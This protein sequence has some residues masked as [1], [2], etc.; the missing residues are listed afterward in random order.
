MILYFDSKGKLVQMLLHVGTSEN[1]TPP[2]Q[3]GPLP[4]YLYFDTT[5][6][7]V[8]SD[9]VIHMRYKTPGKSTFS[10]DCPMTYIGTPN[11]ESYEHEEIGELVD[12]RPY[13][14]YSYVFASDSPA[15]KTAGVVNLSFK[16]YTRTGTASNYSYTNP[17]MLSNA[18]VFVEETLGLAPDAS[19]GM[20]P[21]EYNSL[22]AALN[23]VL[24][25]KQVIDSG[26]GEFTFAKIISNLIYK[27][28][29]EI[30]NLFAAKG[31]DATV[32]FLVKILTAITVQAATIKLN[33][34]DITTLFAAKAG[35]D[36]QDF[37]VKDLKYHDSNNVE[38]SLISKMTTIEALLDSL[39][40][41]DL[42]TWIAAMNQLKDN[43]EEFM[44][45]SSSDNII[46]T[47]TELRTELATK[48]SKTYVDGQDSGLSGEIDT[49]IAAFL[50][51][52]D[53]ENKVKAIIDEMF[54]DISEVEY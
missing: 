20:T 15:V 11:F 40:N 19:I 13:K 46:N 25:L 8:G 30:S 3:C 1:A 21:S 34:Q 26:E 44:T 4:I 42:N 43:F 38:Y 52:S 39:V 24:A 10:E 9:K 54:A 49:K 17:V 7:S 41:S 14:V 37:S 29:V 53:F 31:G 47:L 33:N 12:G 5:N 45:G 28:G 35:S 48:A 6:T 2:R 50:N 23:P 32:D 51:S 22:M 27:N 16:V 36:T 18:N